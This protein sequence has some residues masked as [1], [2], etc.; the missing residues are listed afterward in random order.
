LLILEGWNL[1]ICQ[2][3]HLLLLHGRRRR[4]PTP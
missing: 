4:R 1:G 2:Q 3:Q